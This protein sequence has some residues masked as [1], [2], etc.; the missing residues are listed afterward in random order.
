MGVSRYPGP[1]RVCGVESWRVLKRGSRFCANC[2]RRRTKKYREKNPR[3]KQDR[4]PLRSNCNKCG[5]EKWLYVRRP[6]RTERRCA[7]CTREHNKR[8]RLNNPD[9]IKRIKDRQKHANRERM[10]LQYNM[11][12]EEYARILQAQEGVCAICK[13]EETRL[14]GGKP[15]SLSVDH[16][17]DTGIVRGLLCGHCNLAIGYLCNN[18]KN[19]YSAWR[20]LGGG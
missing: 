7:R 11:S 5:H 14:M 20:Y 12:V 8:W 6:D 4:K 3:P 16:C 15:R 1:C 17:H 18:P 10:L 9:S 19:A 2:S 13:R